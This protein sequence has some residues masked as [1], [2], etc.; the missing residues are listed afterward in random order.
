VILDLLNLAVVVLQKSGMISGSLDLVL[1]LLQKTG[2]QAQQGNG[3]G[4]PGWAPWH[5]IAAL[6]L[7]LTIVSGA[8]LFTYWISKDE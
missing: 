5:L 3:P 7:I 8:C 2:E 6:V 4:G 1:M